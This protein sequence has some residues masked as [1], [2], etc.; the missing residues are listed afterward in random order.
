M[1]R[2][3]WKTFLGFWLATVLIVIGTAIVIHEVEPG[4]L[5][6][7]S[8]APFFNKDPQAM[9]L[10]HVATRDAVNANHEEFIERLHAMPPW[11]LR[12]VFVADATGNELL[13]RN[14]PEPVR[15]L[16]DKLNSNY[17][18]GRLE[19]GKKQYFGRLIQL[20]DGHIVRMVVTSSEGKPNFLL[21]LFLV[22]FWPI[23]L[24]GIIIS[25]SLCFVLA[26]YLSKPIE[27][28]KKATHRIAAGDLNY[29]VSPLMNNRRDEM[30]SLAAD[31][32][33]MSRQLQQSMDAQQRLI[34]DVSHELRSPLMRLQFALGLAQ[35]KATGEASED[36]NKARMAADYLNN[37]ISD[38][39]S[40]P[41]NNQSDWPLDDSIDLIPLI[42]CLVNE[43]QPTA[44]SKQITVRFSHNEIE[45]A[46][47][48]TRGN[49]L[50]G[51]L[52][53]VISNALRHAPSHSFVSL[54]LKKI[55]Q[56]WIIDICDVGPGVAS[57][58]LEKIFSPF[59][60]TDEAR[61]RNQGGS[62]LGL[63]I[64]RRTIGLHHGNISARA[65][66]PQG[67]TISISLPCLAGTD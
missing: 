7:R 51:V 61:D 67:L 40:L 43:I 1:I 10:L 42:D 3:F 59:F 52:D 11:V 58:Y 21:Q 24:V 64:A 56:H 63:S 39:L 29:R 31:F 54:H 57:E 28:L 44:A 23:L 62:G 41:H 22:G 4:G 12:N 6:P 15:K 8:Q 34:K 53:N 48:A 36:I 16:M 32:D 47:V 49:T 50:V 17:P 20:Q 9:R 14:L 65:N 13:K 66:Q 19:R 27:A 60:R 37:I 38:I 45:S 2:L 46:L 33:E 25:G 35:Q 55:E 26:R 30:G 18:F 5:P